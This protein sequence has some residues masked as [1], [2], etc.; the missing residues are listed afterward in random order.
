MLTQ[1]NQSINQ[2]KRQ[3]WSES[4]LERLYL[5]EVDVLRGRQ[6]EA[7]LVALVLQQSPREAIGNLHVAAVVLPCVRGGVGQQGGGLWH[8]ARVQK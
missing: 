8:V 7:L 2:S 5:S 3:R 6:V 1:K 4:E